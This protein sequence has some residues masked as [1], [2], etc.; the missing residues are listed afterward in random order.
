M[1]SDIT[2]SADIIKSK[3]SKLD[4]SI[5]TDYHFH[6]KSNIWKKKHSSKN[7]IYQR[8]IEYIKNKSCSI[9]HDYC[10]YFVKPYFH[11][12]FKKIHRFVL[13]IFF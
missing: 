4:S 8:H 2:I 6:S 7:D 5:Q 10:L 11:S 12:F 3:T 1:P 13:K 9:D